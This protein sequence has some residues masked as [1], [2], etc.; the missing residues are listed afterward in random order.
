MGDAAAAGFPQPGLDVNVEAWN[1]WPFQ[2][3]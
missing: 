1:N 2:A 3:V